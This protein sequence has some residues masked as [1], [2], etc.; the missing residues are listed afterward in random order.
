MRDENVQEIAELLYNEIGY[1]YCDN[2]RFSSEIIEE[3]SDEWKCDEC[4]RKYNG[5]GISKIL[6]YY[7]IRTFLLRS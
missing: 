3:D 1:M 5:W 6:K 4:H 2:C 7:N